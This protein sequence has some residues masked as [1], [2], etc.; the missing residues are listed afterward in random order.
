MHC[1]QDLRSQRRKK[2][3]EISHQWYQY[4]RQADD[5]LKWLDDIEQKLANLPDPQDE[6]K[7]KV[8]PF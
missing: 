5:L 7:L 8:I 3:L 4:K 6:Q 1:D 2:A